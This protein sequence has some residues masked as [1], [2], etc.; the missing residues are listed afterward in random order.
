[1]RL[2]GGREE[3]LTPHV[4]S[5][6][7]HVTRRA[8]ANEVEDLIA[9]II[10]HCAR[11][12]PKS[13]NRVPPLSLDRACTNETA[14]ICRF[15]SAGR[16]RPQRVKM[17]SKRADTR[18]HARTCR[19]PGWDTSEDKCRFGAQSCCAPSQRCVRPR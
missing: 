13:R 5:H 2:C 18:K 6:V 1:M 10:V 16:P 9:V 7:W 11:Q 14:R 17:Q 4:R 15:R 8:C 19:S 12:Q 3:L